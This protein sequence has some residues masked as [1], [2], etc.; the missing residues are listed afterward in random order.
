MSTKRRGKCGGENKQ[1]EKEGKGR[2]GAFIKRQEGVRRKECA[3]SLN[4]ARDF[5]KNVKVNLCCS[6]GTSYPNL[7]LYK[8]IFFCS[9]NYIR[10][11]NIM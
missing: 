1:N 3:R 4:C 10:N 6:G 7:I 8:V 11:L 9:T 5:S 2:K